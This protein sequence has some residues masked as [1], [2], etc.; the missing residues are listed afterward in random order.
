[1]N[2]YANDPRV[3]SDPYQSNGW[4]VQTPWVLFNVVE[5]DDGLFRAFRLQDSQPSNARKLGVLADDVPVCAS[6][7]EAIRELI[8]DPR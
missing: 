3:Q 8:G 1:V 2:A 6:A 5:G 7:D 4:L